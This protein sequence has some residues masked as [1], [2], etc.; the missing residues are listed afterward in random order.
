MAALESVAVSALVAG[1]LDIAA[2]GAVMRAQTVPF[3]RLLQFVAS[4]ALGGSAFEGGAG[5]A[6]VGLVLH[7]LVAAIW[8]A[9]YYVSARVWPVLL[10]RPLLWGTL[11]GVVVHLAMSGVVVPLSRAAKRPFIW[12]AWLTQLGIHIVCVGV[13]IAVMQ[14][15]GLR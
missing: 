8:A 7:F 13:P 15:Y 5:I 10:V 11:Y 1:T 3:R 2:T 9:I 6:A 14:S 4:G 12:K